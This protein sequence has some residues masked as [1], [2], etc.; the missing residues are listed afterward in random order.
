MII[1][2]LLG[3]KDFKFAPITWLLFGTNVFLFFFTLQGNEPQMSSQLSRR[4]LQQTGVYYLQTL[5]EKEDRKKELPNAI[6]LFLWGGKALRDPVFL[7]KID[8]Y[9]FQGHPDDIRDWRHTLHKFKNSMEEKITYQFGVRRS[10]SEAWRYPMTWLTYQFMHADFFHLAG[11]M[12]FLLVFGIAIETLLGPAVLLQTYLV[13]GVM[14]AFFSALV[15]AGSALP[16]VGA[17]ASISALIGLYL[18]VE[19]KKRIGF[20]YFLAPFPGF[21]GEVFLSKLWL[22]PLCLLPDIANWVTDRFLAPGLDLLPN[23]VATSAHI[24]GVLW[25]TLVASWL[26]RKYIYIHYLKNRF[27]LKRQQ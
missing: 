6:E 17:S 16:M 19:T 20:L 10:G 25:G 2:W 4:F 9:Q 23:S 18:I 26:L 27:D 7:S 8:D 24:G 3:I 22:V 5:S 11:N 13:G 15:D 14:G 1:P 21:H 12:I